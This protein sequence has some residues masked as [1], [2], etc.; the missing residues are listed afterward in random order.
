LA[1][2]PGHLYKR[3]QIDKSVKKKIYNQ[4]VLD[5]PTNAMTPPE[6]TVTLLLK[7]W[8]KG[9]SEALDELMPLVY[10]ELRKIAKRF[11]EQE[12]P[13]HTLQTTAV[14]HEAYLK[15]AAGGEKDWENRA[16]FF[17]VAAK[18]MRHILVDH[19]RRRRAAKRGGVI[20]IVPLE[21]G[22]EAAAVNAAEIVALDDALTALAKAD[23][24]KE[25]VVELRY[26]GGLSVEETAR[27]LNI[28]AETVTR[29]WKFARAFLQHE[30]KR[31]TRP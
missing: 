16:H 5:A 13:N 14:L 12:N 19:V 27:V 1:H 22:R 17:A 25:R 21:E 8:A 26:F 29:D 24:R 30:I 4:Q 28:S 15:L 20:R 7:K 31:G 2:F 9:D 10:K 6:H 23:A 11:M 3:K 18:A